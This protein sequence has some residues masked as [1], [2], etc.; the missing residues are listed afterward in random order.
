[1]IPA[2]AMRKGSGTFQ[3]HTMPKV[4]RAMAAVG[5][6][7]MARRPSTK[8]APAMAPVVVSPLPPIQLLRPQTDPSGVAGTAS[9]G[10]L[11]ATR[12]SRAM[13][14]IRTAIKPKAGT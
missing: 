13:S 4:A 8:A 7:K 10:S 14:A 6:S 5:R 11:T 2:A 1:M 12:K 9:V 3:R